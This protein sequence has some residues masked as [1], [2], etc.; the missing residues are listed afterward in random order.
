[1]VELLAPVGDKQC[2]KAAIQNGANAVY[3]GA[4]LFSARAFAKNFDDEDLK[5]AIQY[6]KLRKVKTHL[7]LNTLIKQNELQDAFNLAKKAYEYGIDAII[8]QDIGLAHTLIKYFPDLDIHAST[9]MTIHNLEG[10]KLLENLG[11][12]RV[13]LSRELP[14][15]EIEYICKNSKIEIETFIHGALCISYSGQCL[16]SSMI[17]GRSGNRGQCAQ[18]C[19]L[20]YELV[21]SKNK[22]LDKGYLLSTRDLCS[23]ELL[24]DLIKTGVTSLKIEGRMKSPEYVATV[25]RIYRKYIDLAYKYLGG[26][27]DKYIVDENDL[28]D[29]MQVFNRGG[30]SSGHLKSTGNN[31]LIYKNKPNNMG[32]YLGKIINYNSKKG[33][34]TAKPE[35]ELSIGDSISFSNETSK[36]TVSELM[37]KNDNIKLGKINQIVTFGRMKG[38]INIGDKIYKITDKALSDFAKKSFEKE[39]I[40]THLDCTLNIHDNQKIYISIYSK[41]FNI[42]ID[43][44]YDYLPQKAKNS[45]ITK[46]T[47]IK[48]FNKTLDTCFTFDNFQINLDDN[49][50]IPVSILNDIRRNALN[51]IEDEIISSFTRNS[52]A[53]FQ[54]VKRTTS[55]KVPKP[56]IS[57]LLDDL[58]VNFNSFND[59]NRLYIP[60]KFFTDN[61]FE[62]IIDDLSKQAKIYIYFPTIM[63]KSTMEYIKNNLPNIVSKFKIDGIVISNIS[64]LNLTEYFDEA[65]DIVGNYTLNVY[66]SLSVNYLKSL[67]INTVTLSPELSKTEINDICQFTNVSKE[68]IVKSHIPI[69]TMNYCLLGKSNKCTKNCNRN[70]LGT[71][72]FYLKDRFSVKYKIV[73]D[74]FTNTTTIYDSRINSVDFSNLGIDSIRFDNDTINNS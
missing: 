65:I 18:P 15:N 46:D 22:V 28:K 44:T 5:K 26:K 41:D 71:D 24:P 66:N 50:F 52:N 74:N 73:A 27:I 68:L 37:C 69:M 2:L 47:V 53:K 25:T 34:V 54:I 57:I 38:S 9:Q 42:K 32:L 20:P 62:N 63:R 29:L 17:G 21:N 30:F 6:A 55:N 49:L 19:R 72:S 39:N 58:N 48:Q 10:V 43:F 59:I 70:C 13:V 31:E 36:Y 51:K 40:K 67:N 12:K 14:I 35:T 1:M 4:N 61:K 56:A 16:F 23:L 11:F 64:Q 45:P 3:F 33:L 60:I 7:T 8:V